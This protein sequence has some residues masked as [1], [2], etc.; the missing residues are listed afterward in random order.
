[1]LAPLVIRQR[2]KQNWNFSQILSSILEDL[3]NSSSTQT[4]VMMA[5]RSDRS[6][7][8]K[9]YKSKRVKSGERGGQLPTQVFLSRKC[10]FTN[11]IASRLAEKSL[12]YQG[13]P[14]WFVVKGI[15]VAYQDKEKPVMIL[16]QRRNTRKFSVNS[17]RTEYIKYDVGTILFWSFL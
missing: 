6:W 17:T 16:T 1:M 14:A 11:S 7:N 8:P 9:S 5:I 13:L 4:L 15:S 2:Q 12:I 10:W 3:C